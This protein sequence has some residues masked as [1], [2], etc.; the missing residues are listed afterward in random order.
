MCHGVHRRNLSKGNN[1]PRRPLCPASAERGAAAD[2]AGRD[3][4]PSRRYAPARPGPDGAYSA[5][6][7]SPEALM[8]DQPPSIALALQG[9]G[10]HGAFTWG[11]L[12]RLLQEVAAGRL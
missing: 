6:I 4:R 7:I 12:D 9:G 8:P 1:A 2:G 3:A 10:S 5:G 11:V